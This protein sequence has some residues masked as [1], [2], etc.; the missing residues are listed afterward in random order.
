MAVKID[1]ADGLIKSQTVSIKYIKFAQGSV[2]KI[3]AKF[4]EEQADFYEIIL[5]RYTELLGIE[6]CKT[7]I[8][9][10]ALNIF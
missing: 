7:K 9:T 8:S 5:F 3:H 10:K 1:L 2:S 4:S 6:K